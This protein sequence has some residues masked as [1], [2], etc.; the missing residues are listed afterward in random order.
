MHNCVLLVDDEAEVREN[1]RE[2][3]ELYGYDVT[4]AENGRRALEVVQTDPPCMVLLDLIM[5]VMDGWD[6]L[7]IVE[8]EGIGGD[9]QI[10]ISTSAPEKAPT[11]LPLLAKPVDLNELLR[12]V[13]GACRATGA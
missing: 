8:Q 5:P 6:F 12:V 9:M 7:S 10:V 1:L 11:Q 13:E 3:L 4:V 2:F